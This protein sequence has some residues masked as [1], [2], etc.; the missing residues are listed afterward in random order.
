MAFKERT[1]KSDQDLAAE[2]K[3]IAGADKTADEVEKE[4]EVEK[5]DPNAVRKK[6]LGI[7]VNDYE[8][9]LLQRLADKTDRTISAT[10]R[11]AINKAIKDHS[12]KKRQ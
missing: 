3:F 7:K 5:L 4:A 10:I 6:Q 1:I 8:M 9:L 12:V 11:Y 2:E